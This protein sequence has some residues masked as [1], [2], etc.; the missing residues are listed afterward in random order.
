MAEEILKPINV[1]TDDELISILTV[2]KD[3]F[4]DNYKNDVLSELNNRGV[5]L[6]DILKVARFKFNLGDVEKVDV[7]S[8]SEKLSLL[9][10]PLDVIYFINYMNEHYAVQKNANIY[11]V[12]HHTPDFGF[13]SFF[14]ENETVLK[15]SLN[16]FLTLDE[17]LPED[18][19]IIDH[20][21]TFV[22]STSSAYIQRIA[23]M[24]DEIEIDYCANSLQMVRFSSFNAPY[25]I[26]L[27]VEYMEDA[28]E[29]LDKMEELKE[30]LHEQ[31]QE[32]DKQ[33][34]VDRQLKLLT[35]LESVTPE[36]PVLFYNK[37]QLLDEK[38]EFQNASDA[39]IESF[40]LEFA[41]GD[42]EDID[43]THDYLVSMI[44]KVESK[45]NIL[46]CL[47]TIATFKNEFED[48]FKY[49]NELISLDKNDSIAHLNLGH[50]YYSHTEE[51]DKVKF[52]F[53]KFKELEPESNEIE[54]IDTILEVLNS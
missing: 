19:E 42:I 25:S 4:N 38:G 41:Q 43:E 34:E 14:V 20:W 35:E 18:T 54:S 8:A 22:E 21:E 36:D 49:F 9:K 53:T 7:T 3:N 37:A 39:L 46:H 40:N 27:P 1:M 28:G 12:H 26:V 23:K 32:A 52:H 10:E 30:R 24:L 33:G 5:N 44:D 16:N 29:V 15:K 6:E 48:A 45:T 50:L 47:A 13:S 51:D 17:W 31:L 2:K 11:V